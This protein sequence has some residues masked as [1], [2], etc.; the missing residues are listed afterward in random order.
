M[1]NTSTYTLNFYRCEWRIEHT[2]IA[3]KSI[4]CQWENLSSNWQ[5]FLGIITV[6]LLIFACTILLT[7]DSSS[8]TEQAAGKQI[9]IEMLGARWF[10]IFHKPL[11]NHKIYLIQ[12]ER[13]HVTLNILQR[14]LQM[15]RTFSA[16]GLVEPL[17]LIGVLAVQ[18]SIVYCSCV[19]FVRYESI[20]KTI[21][22]R[23]NSAPEIQTEIFP[24]H[25]QL[26]TKNKTK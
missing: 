14:I 5:W 1:A 21:Q 7:E 19:H 16:I 2:Y 8:S 11:W 18:Y 20:L 24:T 22:S 23:K 10:R 26:N 25:L 17:H 13:H 6:I 12:N 15:C 4:G 9:P 3:A